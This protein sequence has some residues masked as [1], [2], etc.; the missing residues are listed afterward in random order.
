MFEELHPVPR[1]NRLDQYLGLWAIEHSMFAALWSRVNGMD[2]GSHIRQGVVNLEPPTSRDGGICRIEIRGTMTKHGSSLSEAGATTMIRHAV[3]QAAADQSCGGIFLL[4]DTPGGT[5][6]GTQELFDDIKA[7]AAIKPV[8]SF[9]EDCC[10]SAGMFGAAASSKIFANTPAAWVGSIGSLM[11][12][13]DMSAAAQEAGVVPV[14]IKTGEFKSTGVPGTP[15]T[16]EQQSELQRLADSMQQG[17]TN[18]IK[19]RGLSADQMAEVLSARVYPA[20]EGVRLQLIDGILT[21][22]QALAELQ[23]MISQKGAKTM[24]TNTQAAT[25][26]ELRAALPNAGSD[27]LVQQIEA[28]ATISAATGK[29]CDILQAQLLAANEKLTAATAEIDTLKSQITTMKAATGKHEAA[30]DVPTGKTK[31]EGEQTDDMDEDETAPMQWNRL[32]NQQV[33]AGMSRPRAASIVAKKHPEL[34]ER[35][36]AEANQGRSARA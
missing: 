32:I 12:L 22:Q 5:A 31:P 35:M 15:I 21:E 24:T 3:R 13:Y 30:A 19:S 29:Y 11:V 36:I 34:R 26:A 23:A 20:S 25:L 18:A 27:F 1:F 9:V 2:L 10:C 17:F 4:W 28:G 7:A 16:P 14:V 6:A 33:K 8:V